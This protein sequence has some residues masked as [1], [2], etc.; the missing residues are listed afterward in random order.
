[1]VRACTII[2]R[3]YLAHARVLAKS[4]FA[5]HADGS[6]TVLI[7]DDERRQFDDRHEAFTALRL[8]EI[9]LEAGEIG[10]LASIYDVT[11][12]ATAV[13][14]PLLRHLLSQHSDIIYIDPDTRI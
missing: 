6:F 5:H 2:A 1:M 11:E 3:N 4:F 9:G 13:K 7:V 8:S 14:P 10:R 12:L